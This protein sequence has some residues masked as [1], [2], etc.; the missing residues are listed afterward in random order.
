[1][2]QFTGH[3]RSVTS[4]AFHPQGH[5]V[6]TGS[7]DRTARLWDVA[8]GRELCKLTGHGDWVTSVAFH[9]QGHQVLTGSDDGTARL[10]DVPGVSTADTDSPGARV[11]LFV[12][13]NYAP[14]TALFDAKGNLLDWDDEAIDT[15]LF[16]L[17]SGTPEPIETV[18]R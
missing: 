18:I 4:V 17:A 7:A 5:Q 11:R 9:P 12:H 16:S 13:G 15:W 2:R 3:G 1:M 10:W 6:L 14:S 8:S